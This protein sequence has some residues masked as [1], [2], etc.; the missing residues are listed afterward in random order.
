M[1]TR[2]EF[3]DFESK[4]YFHNQVDMDKVVILITDYCTIKG[5]DTAWINKFIEGLLGVGQLLLSQAI[6]VLQDYYEKQFEIIKII[7]SNNRIVKIY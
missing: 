6:P 5:K 7:D 2:E 3:L 1:M 4:V